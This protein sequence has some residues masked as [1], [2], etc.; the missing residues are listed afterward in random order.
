MGRMW[1]LV[2][3]TATPYLSLGLFR[4]RRGW[5]GSSGWKGGT[6]KSSSASWRRS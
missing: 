2:L 6:R 4:G 1:T 5:A 3:D